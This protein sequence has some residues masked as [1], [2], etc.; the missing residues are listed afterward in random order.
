MKMHCTCLK[1]IEGHSSG[2]CTISH[3]TP[4]LVLTNSTYSTVLVLEVGDLVYSERSVQTCTI[5]LPKPAKKQT[6]GFESDS[7]FVS[8]SKGNKVPEVKKM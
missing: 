8:C 1:G 7:L 5:T 6:A 3:S 4:M 2:L